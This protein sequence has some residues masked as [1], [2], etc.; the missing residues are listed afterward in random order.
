MCDTLTVCVCHCY[1]PSL[2]LILLRDWFLSLIVYR[3][4]EDNIRKKIRDKERQIQQVKYRAN[5]RLLKF[6]A[7]MPKL[8]NTIKT[9]VRDGRFTKPP[10]GPIGD[11]YLYTVNKIQISCCITGVTI[12]KTFVNSMLS[13]SP[14]LKTFTP[15]S[16]LRYGKTCKKIATCFATLIQNEWNKDVT[17]WYHPRNVSNRIKSGCYRLRKVVAE[18]SELFY[19]ATKSVH[20]ACAFYRPIA[21]LLCN[22]WPTP[23]Y[24]LSPAKFYPIRSQY[25]H[26]LQQPDL[27]Q[28]GFEW[29]H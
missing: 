22:K 2:L 6:G 8:V 14:K 18:S 24:G 25:S 12:V 4:D 23:V 11:I 16:Y 17:R 20:V 29:G 19:F 5:D 9:A 1:S 21:D 10:R 27:L 13:L 28:D 3:Q 15:L 26:N 7:W